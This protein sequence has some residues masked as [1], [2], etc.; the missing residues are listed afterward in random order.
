MSAR[1]DAA[2][3]SSTPHPPRGGRRIALAALAGASL[4]FLVAAVLVQHLPP[5]PWP[6]YEVRIGWEGGPPAPQEWPRAARPG[7]EARCARDGDC[8][9]LVVRSVRGEEA[10]ALAAELRRRRMS[11][12]DGSAARLAA[13]RA[14]WRQ[15]RQPD[16]EPRL[17]P[18]TRS[19]AL[20]RGRLLLAALLDPAVPAAAPASTPAADGARAR[21]DAA[22]AEVARLARAARPDSLEAALTACAAAEG[23]WLRELAA[24]PEGV[25]RARLEGAWGWHERSRTAELDS[26]ARRLEAGLPEQQRALVPALAFDRFGI[27]SRLA[28]AGGAC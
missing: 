13:A 9:W 28:A 6:R 23:E 24:H 8:A 2:K 19:A 12:L 11:G 26:I 16:P 1:D 20:L 14:R 18:A 22:G 15:G 27:D 17:S 10:C 4:G 25:S 7:E 5:G 21:L 3:L